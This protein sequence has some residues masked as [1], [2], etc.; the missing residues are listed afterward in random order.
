MT[1]AAAESPSSVVNEQNPWPGLAPFDEAAAPFFNDLKEDEE[2]EWADDD[3][4]S[5]LA[6]PPAQAAPVP[7][8]RTSPKIGR[9]D[10]CP[11]G[12]GKKYKKCCGK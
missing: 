9:N 2:L 3:L 7:I 12:S 5:D 6:P 8:R 11:C 4:M 10:P 1:T